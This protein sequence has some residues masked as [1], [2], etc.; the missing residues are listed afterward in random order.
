MKLN[1]Q[2]LAATI[3]AFALVS[4]SEQAPKK[5]ETSDSKTEEV[6]VTVEAKEYTIDVERSVIKWTG[7]KPTEDHFGTLELDAS[8]VTILENGVMNGEIVV[9]MGSVKV[10]DIENE[11]YNAKLVGHL[12]N[13]DF[14]NVDSFPT[15]Q[16]NITEGV[17]NDSVMK[18]MGELTIKG[19]SNPAELEYTMMA[20]SNGF[21]VKGTHSF[22]RTKYD[23]KYKSKT[24]FGDL[25][26]KFILDDIKLEYNL[27]LKEVPAK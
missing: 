15:A 16:F 2:I 1:N 13:E 3:A 7:S 20:D 18:V 12:K 24:I 26:D 22:D 11:E 14:F 25:G 27:F 19:I 23:I 6:A 4:C 9:N 10:T 17:A 21:V 8:S 5:T